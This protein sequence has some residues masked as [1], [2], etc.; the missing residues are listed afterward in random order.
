M[1]VRKHSVLNRLSWEL[2][3]KQTLINDIVREGRE[4]HSKGKEQH[5]QNPCGRNEGGRGNSEVGTNRLNQKPEEG[6]C[7]S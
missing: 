1:A 5:V 6:S 3:D 2:E 4:Y 7:S